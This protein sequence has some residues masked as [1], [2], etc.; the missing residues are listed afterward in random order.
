[1]TSVLKATPRSHINCFSKLDSTN[2]G[3]VNSETKMSESRNFEEAS[4]QIRENL[5]RHISKFDNILDEEEESDED[6]P[7]SDKIVDD[8]LSYYRWRPLFSNKNYLFALSVKLT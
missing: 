7:V 4:R 3:D 1:M 2:Y 5:N 8:L 6:C